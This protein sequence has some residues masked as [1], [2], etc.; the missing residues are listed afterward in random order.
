MDDRT[1]ARIAGRNPRSS[2]RK[3]AVQ[4]RKRE[5]M[6]LTTSAEIDQNPNFR[7]I[8]SVI[9]TGSAKKKIRER[10]T[11]RIIWR[12]PPVLCG[13]NLYPDIPAGYGKGI[14][15]I[16][17][18]FLISQYI[19]MVCIG[20]VC[21]CEKSNPKFVCLFV[22]SFPLNFVVLKV[23]NFINKLGSAFLLC[24]L[25]PKCTPKKEGIC[26]QILQ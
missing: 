15:F 20:K 16:L 11:Q 17:T 23:S 5:S 21:I 2:P 24:K 19:C 7:W 13:Y 18:Y 6:S 12:K 26:Y 10:N 9:S 25:L 22:C 1:S 8:K 4:E 3:Q 14:I